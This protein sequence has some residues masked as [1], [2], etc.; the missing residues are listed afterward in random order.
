[1]NC[2][3]LLQ[4]PTL[5]QHIAATSSIIITNRIKDTFVQSLSLS[6]TAS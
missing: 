1:M 3:E 5:P 2:N 4:I 6:F